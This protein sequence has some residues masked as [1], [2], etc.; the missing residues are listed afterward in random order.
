MKAAEISPAFI[1]NIRLAEAKDTF[2]E[3]IRAEIDAEK[4]LRIVEDHRGVLIRI[5]RID[6]VHQIFLPEPPRHK[7]LLL[8]HY[9]P[10]SGQPR[11]QRCTAS[12][13]ER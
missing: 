6:E 4:N 12:Y 10:F 13:G 7:I 8:A 5:V 9:T 11:K 1:G 3:Q 2:C